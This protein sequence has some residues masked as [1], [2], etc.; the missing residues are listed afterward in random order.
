MYANTNPRAIG[1]FS[2]TF[3]YKNFDLDVLFTYQ[4]G[5]SLYFGT[6]AGMFDQRFWNNS[7]RVLDGWRK[8][9]DVTDIPKPVYND[10]VSNGSGLPISFNVFKADFIKLKNVTL[11]YNIPVDGLKKVKITNARFWVGGQNLWIFTKYPGP[12]PEVS[13]NGNG[14]PTGQGVDRNTLANGRTITVGLNIGF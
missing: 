4:A 1:G 9:G 6:N 10:N 12:D 8:F 5:F 14:A 11:G 7:V 3:R 2:N 13:S